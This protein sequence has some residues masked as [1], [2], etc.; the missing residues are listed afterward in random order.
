[1]LQAGV[2]ACAV[3]CGAALANEVV[4]RT[5]D[6]REQ[7]VISSATFL[8]AHPDMSYRIKGRASYESGDYTSAIR[9]FTL[10]AKYA[11][12]P[13]Q[14][15]LAEMSWQGRGV[16]VDRA[17]AYAW[18]DL[19]AE[20]GYRQF[21]ELRE[22]YWRKLDARERARAIQHGQG[23]L[24]DYGDDVALPRMTAFLLKAKRDTRT[25][26][27]VRPPRDV[28]VPG[29][30][31]QAKR[32][33]GKQFFAAKFWEPVQYQAWQDATWMDPPRGNV[34]VG[35]VEQVAPAGQ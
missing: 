19:S 24:A 15:M 9:Y 8:N 31:G 23:L 21:A 6:F 3:I 1:M 4:E 26:V 34:D 14:A 32:I 13:S 18:A 10:A 22:G 20:R 30:N 2:L 7:R 25:G 27:S 11:D 12:K 17:V 35:D 33:S 16:P 5:V 28:V 29:P